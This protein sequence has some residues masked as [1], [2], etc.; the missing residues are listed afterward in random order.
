MR[1]HIEEKKI[2][3][4]CAKDAL[5]NEPFG[6]ALADLLQLIANFKYVPSLACKCNA[7]ECQVLC[8]FEGEGTCRIEG[9]PMN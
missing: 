3:L 5:V 9:R 4:L 8:S 7:A 1:G 2:A 6:K